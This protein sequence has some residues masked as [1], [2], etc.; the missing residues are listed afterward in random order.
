MSIDLFLIRRG[1]LDGSNKLNVA[2]AVDG[3]IDVARDIAGL[4]VEV[5]SIP[6]NTAFGTS[7]TLFIN[8]YDGKTVPI[9]ISSVAVSWGE[10]GTLVVCDKYDTKKHGEFET[11]YRGIHQATFPYSVI[12]ALVE[13]AMSRAVELELS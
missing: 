2:G 8:Y 11:V 7:V 6:T 13:V 1:A 10:R 3:F 5:I 12:R 9:V 4:G